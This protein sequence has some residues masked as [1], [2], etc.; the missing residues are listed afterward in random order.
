MPSPIL[1]FKGHEHSKHPISGAGRVENSP[2]SCI[3]KED[4]VQ[5]HHEVQTFH[6]IQL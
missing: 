6:S 3:L 1:V 4:L 2:C 5:L